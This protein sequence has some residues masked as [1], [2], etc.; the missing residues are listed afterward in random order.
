[1][2]KR[3]PVWSARVLIIRRI[4]RLVRSEPA[5]LVTSTRYQPHPDRTRRRRSEADALSATCRRTHLWRTR[6]SHVAGVCAWLATGMSTSAISCSAASVIAT[7]W[8]SSRRSSAR[9]IRRW[10]C[11]CA[12]LA[13]SYLQEVVFHRAGLSADGQPRPD[14]C[15]AAGAQGHQPRIHQQRWRASVATRAGHSRFVIP[16]RRQPL[17]TDT[18]IQFGD[19]YQVKHQPEKALTL[20]SARRCAWSR[21]EQARSS[22]K[23]RCGTAEFPGA[24]FTIRCRRWPCVI[25]SCRPRTTEEKFVSVQFTVTG[26]GECAGC[27]SDRTERLATAGVRGAGSDSARHAIGRKFVNGEPVETQG[28]VNREVFR[29]RKQ[30]GDDS[31]S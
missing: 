26:S 8:R 22:P 21:M 23:R 10:C 15:H 7:P 19:W 29:I 17:L 14:G 2:K 25:V 9:T 5:E 13:R 16:T 24:A 4:F 27:E 28:V 6:S 31:K 11:R 18:L 1:M 3:F 12:S 20:L 30:D